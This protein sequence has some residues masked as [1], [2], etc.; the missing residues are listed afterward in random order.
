MAVVDIWNQCCIYL[1]IHFPHIQSTEV[2][3]KGFEI[4][5]V[6]LKNTGSSIRKRVREKIYII[7]II[8]IVIVPRGYILYIYSS[9]Y[10]TDI[11]ILDV[12]IVYKK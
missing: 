12:Y 1:D 9:F 10:F 5:C 11:Y 3:N 7:Y 8:V 2:Q 4:T 6:Y